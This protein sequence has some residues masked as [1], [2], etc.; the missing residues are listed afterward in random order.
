MV[1]IKN[2]IE[3]NVD[4]KDNKISKFNV[5]FQ[6]SEIILNLSNINFNIVKIL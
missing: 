4:N 2:N 5:N 6:N 3:S 1:P